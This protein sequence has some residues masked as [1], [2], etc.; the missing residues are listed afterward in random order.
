M[1]I[2]E[3]ITRRRRIKIFFV[4]IQCN[5]ITN[6]KKIFLFEIWDRILIGIVIRYIINA[7]ESVNC[8]EIV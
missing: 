6:R 8:D 7:H 4:V 1:K 2:I 5:C 3:K